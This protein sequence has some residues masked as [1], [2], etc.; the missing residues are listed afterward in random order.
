MFR[1]SLRLACVCLAACVTAATVGGQT[2]AGTLVPPGTRGVVR[3]SANWRF[4]VDPPDLGEKEQWY[5]KDFDRA[6]WAKVVVPKAWDLY[7]EALWTYAGVGW[8]TTRIDGALAR[9]GKIQRLQFG[10][11]NY[12]TK[13]WL[14]GELLGENVISYLPFEFD[15]TDKLK[16][17]AANL[18][19]LRVDNRHRLTWL[20]G[21]KRIE[22]IQ[23]GGILEP[24]TLETTAKVYISDLTIH[25]VPDGSGAS[26]ACALEITS[27]EDAERD[28]VLRVG[29]AGQAQS[30]KSVKLKVAPGA[31]VVE[32]VTLS[33]AEANP[34][35]P[36]KPFLYSLAATL[37]AGKPVDTVNARFG[38][39]KIEA[40]GREI[41]LNG[42]RF[43]AKG[44]NRYDE[45]GKYGPQPPRELLIADL[46]RMKNAGVNMVR[47]H[48]PQSPEILSLYD[49]MGFVMS[50]EV[51][52]NWW[53]N[54]FSG[55]DEEVQ[56]ENILEQGMPALERMI[57]RDKNHP[58]III[59]SMC[60]ESQTANEVGIG[61][62]RKL[63]RRA[64]ELDQS[65]LVTFVVATNDVKLHRA[66]E[67]ADLVAVNDY[68][69]SLGGKIA[70]HASEL[71]ELVTKPSEE[72]IRRQLAGIPDKPLLITEFGTF[73][74]PG[75]HG[76]V[77]FTEDF[78]AA[79]I[80]AAWKAIQNCEEASGGVL[81]S[82]ADYYHG[83]TYT[84][85]AAFG[86]YGIVTVDRRPKAALAA[87]AK[88]YGGKVVEPAAAGRGRTA[89]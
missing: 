64:K 75:M 2:K 41:L 68:H 76:D 14:N 36:E 56:S 74:V 20:P 81:W 40:R 42:R 72:F 71:E 28:V 31:K 66:F 79:L 43:R 27:R 15:V 32:N 87:L 4:Q 35:S 29:V 82:W 51:P 70:R 45:Y 39:R 37:E 13:V 9:K 17:G 88:M 11:V 52:I 24:V 77:Q 65:R 50:E 18:L 62:M 85:Q 33:L 38:V 60:N 61:V 10:R 47:V 46:R 3:I 57:A 12:H 34:W 26:V 58:C 78:Q 67:D 8:Y 63:I 80:Q 55:K 69:G 83:R 19:V 48:Y 21:A 6:A 23:Y 53:G 7:D 86:L 30:A 89:Q 44:V 16:P 54:N 59:W 1:N 5:A 73:G 49:E 22:W 25:A 84:Q